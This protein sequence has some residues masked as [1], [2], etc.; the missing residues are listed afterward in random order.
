MEF[1]KRS[2]GL[3]LGWLPLKLAQ[4]V[5]GW[6]ALVCFWLPFR[7]LFPLGCPLS[8][9]PKDKG[10]ISIGIGVLCRLV[11]IEIA[12]HAGFTKLTVSI[13]QGHLSIFPK[14]AHGHEPCRETPQIGRRAHGIGP[15]DLNL[16]SFTL[17]GQRVRQRRIACPCINIYMYR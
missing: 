7:C 2:I 14:V 4:G 11:W 15:Q 9:T 5:H 1:L 12:V 10:V 8:Q 16:L 6:F 3:K 17:M 13:Y